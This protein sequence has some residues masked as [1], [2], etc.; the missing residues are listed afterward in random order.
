MNLL[1]LVIGTSMLFVL[2]ACSD[3][4]SAQ[5]YIAKAEQAIVEKQNNAAIISLKNALKIAD[6]NAHAR[7][8]LG[9]LYLSNGDA[10]NAAKE[11]ERAN[12]LKYAGDKVLPLLAR[13]YI[14]TESDGDVLAL[15]KQVKTLHQP[16][17][18][19]LAYKTMAALRTGDND[20]AEATV[21]TATSLFGSDA[22]SLLASA[23]LEFSKQNTTLT[24]TLVERI[25]TTDANNADAL[26]LQGQAASVEKN[27]ALAVNSFQKYQELQPNSGKVQLFIAD[28][29]LKNGQFKEAEAIAD[30]L[31]AKVPTQ[32]FLQYIKANA[33]FEDKDYQAASR[34]ANQSLS[35][36][37]NTFSLKLVAG[38]SAFYLKNYEQSV[39][40]LKEL[41]PYIADDHPARRMLAVSQ[42][43]LGLIDDISE[44]LNGYDS[45]NK[46][47][48][49]FLATLSYELLEVGAYEQAQK[50]ASYVSTSTDMS[51]EETARVGMLKLMMNDPS[52]I[53]KLELALQKNPELASAELLLAFSSIKSGNLPRATRIANKWLKEYP[54]KAGGHNLQ[55]AIYFANKDLIKGQAALEK[56]LQLEPDNAYA[57]TQ[58]VQLANYQKDTKQAILLTEKAVKVHPDNIQILTQYFD[59]HKND[60]G[61][62]VLMQ[63]QEN[64][65]DDIKYGILLAEALVY[66][67]Q[68][69]QANALLNDY[70][71]DVRTP[72]RYWQL[73]LGIN[74]KNPDGKDA[75]SILE[76]W[77]KTNPYHIESS[78]LLINY[79]TNKRS[80]D[81]ALRV[82]EKADEKH[83]NNLMLHLVKMKIL[84]DN[85]RTSDAKALFETLDKFTINEDLIAGISGRIFLLERNFA[86]AVPKLTQQYQ[87]QPNSNNATYLAFALE[88]N[89]QKAEA[90]ALLENFANKENVEKKIHPRVSLSLANM[91]L[92]EHQDKAIAEY[93]RLIEVLPENIVVLN[94]LSWLYMDQGQFIQALKYAKKAYALNAEIPNVVDTYAQVLLKSGETVEALV[95]AKEA[96]KLSEGKDIDI[97]LNF[98]ETLL[99]NKNNKEAQRLLIGVTGGTAAQQEKKRQLSE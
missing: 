44:T 22:Y 3:N 66:L 17:T 89:N 93:E 73:V 14:L 12:K 85:N 70:K 32:P 95:K 61:L 40:Y 92:A 43:Q 29:L 71:I 56:S 77:Q 19:Y 50:M 75:Y 34:F 58:M 90:I 82:L 94:N 62:K 48:V 21:D 28:A 2:S 37:F 13:A 68:F 35:S 8:L 49:Q 54:E 31:L 91:Y 11:L 64:N 25:L 74:A 52:G 63:A 57:L 67:E 18:Q 47:D 42:L 26:M 55:A 78:F 27:Y 41:M 60:A 10:E 53:D 79:W 7:F 4:E 23:Y 9:R 46:E 59:F 87:A 5:S 99:A 98:A 96:Y 16:S 86:D 1:K 45:K 30:T 76:Q 84:L 39:N 80:P 83:P 69:K 88:G 24:L 15:A 65:K 6:D 36:G 38:A 33:R 81:R 51:A 72:K 20:L 97:T